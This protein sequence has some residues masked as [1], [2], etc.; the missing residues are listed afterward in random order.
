[1]ECC[2]SCVHLS[3]MLLVLSLENY[4]ETCNSAFHYLRNS[5]K[6]MRILSFEFNSKGKPLPSFKLCGSLGIPEVFRNDF[7]T[8]LSTTMKLSHVFHKIEEE[9]CHNTNS[10]NFSPYSAVG[11]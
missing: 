7:E 3:C 8:A 11:F 6:V 4:K 5:W 2:R 1:M 9:N 10:H